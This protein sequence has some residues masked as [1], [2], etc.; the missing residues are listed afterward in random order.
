MAEPIGG[1]RRLNPSPTPDW[2][3]HLADANLPLGDLV[4]LV[5][6][7]AA[8]YLKATA[9][10]RLKLRARCWRSGVRASVGGRDRGLVKRMDVHAGGRRIARDTR[11]PFRQLV[12]RV[13]RVRVVVVLRDG[14]RTAS[15]LTA[16]G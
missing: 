1:A 14:R 10:P 6:R 8:A 5:G 2:G 16:C 7:Q 13:E 3:L 4:E 11:P 9:P 12:R 15:T